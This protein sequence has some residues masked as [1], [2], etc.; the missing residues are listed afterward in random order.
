MQYSF[1]QGNYDVKYS[2]TTFFQDENKT[3][4]NNLYINVD[5]INT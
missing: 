5:V 1:H 2:F 4:I 3:S